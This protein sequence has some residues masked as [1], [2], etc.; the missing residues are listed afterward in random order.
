[1]QKLILPLCGAISFKIVA[2]YQQHCMVLASFT[3]RHT[4]I[5]FMK[6]SEAI[7]Y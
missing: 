1:M 2:L 4:H 7:N 3:A 6:N 5:L